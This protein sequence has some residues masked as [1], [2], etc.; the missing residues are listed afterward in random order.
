M[1]RI[2]PLLLLSGCTATTIYTLPEDVPAKPVESAWGEVTVK[3]LDGSLHSYDNAQ[4]QVT[5]NVVRVSAPPL[6]NEHFPVG[7]V[8]K[9]E[10]GAP[11]PARTALLVGG[12]A[13]GLAIVIGVVAGMAA[14]ASSHDR[15]TSSP[16]PPSVY[17]CRSGYLG[18]SW[19]GCP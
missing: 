11:S 12:I 15:P 19:G 3:E 13:T 18:L 7:A 2:L 9:V 10:I 16:S 1:N 8:S 4:V 5:G 17:T 6:A 14:V